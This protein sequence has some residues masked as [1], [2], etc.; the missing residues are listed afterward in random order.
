MAGIAG[1][2]VGAWATDA[3]GN[4]AIQGLAA[5]WH[6]SPNTWEA[7][8]EAVKAWFEENFNFGSLLENTKR[9][10]TSLRDLF[11]GLWDSIASALSSNVEGMRPQI[12]WLRGSAGLL[13]DGFRPLSGFFVS[14][15]D[16]VVDL[17]NA[18]WDWVNAWVARI[19]SGAKGFVGGLLDSL[20]GSG[21]ML[22]GE[23]ADGLADRA[24]RRTRL[25]AVLG[26]DNLFPHVEVKSAKNLPKNQTFNQSITVIAPAN[27]PASVAAAASRGVSQ[28]GDGMMPQLAWSRL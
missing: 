27:D 15:S 16:V 4:A 5:L 11:V 9:E 22:P 20:E 17:L 28:A 21:P 14:L 26:G 23:T 2:A 7:Q 3:V 24:R 10:F 12:E 6:P 1:G 19:I 13:L 18:F 25:N 8:L